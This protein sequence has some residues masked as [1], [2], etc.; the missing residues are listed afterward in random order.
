MRK[1][2]LRRLMEWGAM[3]VTK[4]WLVLVNVGF[5]CV[6]AKTWNMMGPDVS[7]ATSVLGC[8]RCRWFFDILARLLG[9]IIHCVYGNVH[10]ISPCE[11]NLNYELTKVRWEVF[12]MADEP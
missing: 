10:G 5:P 1:Y 8:I 11:Y 12:H 3:S 9:M 2:W 7:L 6:C 4:V